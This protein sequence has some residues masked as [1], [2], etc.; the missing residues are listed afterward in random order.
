MK[1]IGN[2][3]DIKYSRENKNQDTALHISKVEY[4]TH[5]KDGRFFQPFDLEVELTEPIVI[6]GDRL[7]RIQNPLLEKGE[8]EF[9]V[10]DIVD[11]AYVLNPEKQLS[12]SIEYDFDLDVTILSSL[13]YTVTVSNEEFKEL[14]AEHIK[15]KKQ[16]QKG[17]GKKGR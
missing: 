16:Q 12:L 2:I 8:Y 17:R 3:N 6:T 13:Y 10:Y 4:I 9:E 15:Q 14:K 7:A 1:L 11:N 5:K